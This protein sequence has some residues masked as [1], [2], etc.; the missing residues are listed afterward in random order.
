MSIK[1]SRLVSKTVDHGSHTIIEPVN[2]LRRQALVSCSDKEAAAQIAKADDALSILKHEFGG[3]ME[4]EVAR[5]EASL[6]V[7]VANPVKER[8]QFFRVVHDVRGHAGTF[9]FPLAG[10]IADNLCR[11][12][13]AVSRVPNDIVTAHVFA[14]RAVVRENA[15]TH[16]HPVGI[17]LAQSLEKVTHVLVRG[18]AKV[19]SDKAE[20]DA[21]AGSSASPE[22]GAA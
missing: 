21:S 17:L 20:T 10:R 5:L 3:W 19:P 13:D 12:I 4:N 15:T 8:D 22:P 7:Y 9:G 18:A 1:T 16:D 11:L 14:I 2:N 6:E